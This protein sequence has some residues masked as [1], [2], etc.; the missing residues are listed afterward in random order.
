MVR[1]LRGLVIFLSL[2]EH[3]I[4]GWHCLQH[5]ILLLSSGFLSGGSIGQVW[6][7]VAGSAVLILQLVK[8]I[9]IRI[10]VLQM[11]YGVAPAHLTEKKGDCQN[12]LSLQVL[13]C[14]GKF[15]RVALCYKNHKE[16]M[17]SIINL[18]VIVCSQSADIEFFL[19]YFVKSLY[20][21]KT[22]EME[23]LCKKQLWFFGIRNIWGRLYAFYIILV[24]IVEA[25]DF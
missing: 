16:N 1:Y 22:Q 15:P 12:R 6:I 14:K 7:V 21:L 11:L 13:R 20:S 9:Y 2:V 25:V 18:R 19:T 10:L 8:L 23:P 3:L 4:V 24:F 17:N 5:R